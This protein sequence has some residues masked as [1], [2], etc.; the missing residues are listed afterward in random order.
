MVDRDLFQKYMTSEFHNQLINRVLSTLP[1]EIFH[2]CPSLQSS[3]TKIS[4]VQPITFGA[5][6]LPNAGAWWEK[7]PVK[8]C[9]NDKLINVNFAIGTD[10]KIKTTIGLPGTTHA[11]LI[12]QHDAAQYA[13]SSVGARAKD[14]NQF[15]IVDTRFEGFGLHD[16]AT[17]DP[18]AEAQFRPWWETWTVIGCDHAYDVPMNFM[19]D[20]TGTKITQQ[21]ETVIVR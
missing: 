16:P 20:A 17:P 18:G 9:G 8:G 11:N 15:M 10:G 12:L 3:E 6:G 2:K 13:T 21:A 5:D 19:P 1:P 4:P 7:F 14:C